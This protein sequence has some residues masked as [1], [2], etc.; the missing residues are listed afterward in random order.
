MCSPDGAEAHLARVGQALPEDEPF[1][2]R[3]MRDV[4]NDV[5]VWEGCVAFLDGKYE[6]AR[7]RMLAGIA[8]QPLWLKNRG[9]AKMLVQSIFAR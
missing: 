9:V 5:M 2:K 3:V 8:Q 1:L 6:D 4:R 7:K